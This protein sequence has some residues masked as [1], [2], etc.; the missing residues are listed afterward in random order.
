MAVAGVAAIAVG[1]TPRRPSPIG[2]AALGAL[3]LIPVPV[4]A[5]SN[6][7]GTVTVLAAAGIVGWLTTIV[8]R[9][10]D[11][12]NFVLLALVASAAVQA[13]FAV[14]E[15]HSGHQINFYGSA[16]SASSG[17][18]TSSS[19]T[20]LSVRSGRSTTRSALATCWPWRSL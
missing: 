17:R 3:L 9:E 2:N 18:T 1:P 12:A 10:P 8:A 19:S 14:Y 16:G 15:L 11:G 13:A 6:I 5:G 4:F 20:K 7:A